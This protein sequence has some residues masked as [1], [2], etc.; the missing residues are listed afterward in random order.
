MRQLASEKV[1]PR[2]ILCWGVLGDSIFSAVSFTVAP[3][4][5]VLFGSANRTFVYFSGSWP[6]EKRQEEGDD[7]EAQN[8]QPTEGEQCPLMVVPVS[9]CDDGVDFSS[10]NDE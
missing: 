1:K 4:Y 3:L 6:G 7:E 5:T 8:G 9:L 10:Q 2:F